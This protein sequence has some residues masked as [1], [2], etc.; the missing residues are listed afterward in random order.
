MDSIILSTKVGPDDRI[1][2]TKEAI[3]NISFAVEKLGVYLASIHQLYDYDAMI[4]SISNTLDDFSTA[5]INA[6]CNKQYVAAYKKWGNFGWS[7]NVNIDKK[8]FLTAPN[9][10]K[11]AD[12][13]M[14][15]YCNS[16]T[17]TKMM[18]KLET[19]GV[20]KKDLEEAY[21]DYINGKYKSSVMLLFS[22][23][24]QQ[25]IKRK[26]FKEDGRLKTGAG[27]IGELKKSEKQY[28]GST[29]LNYLQFTLIIYCLLKLFESSEN[30]EIEPDVINRNFLIHGMSEKEVNEDDCLKVW[31]ALYSFVVV[32]PELEKE[33]ILNSI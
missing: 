11:E 7:F 14:R 28:K 21:F 33:I 5:L 29:H 4:S 3:E 1:V 10:L 13:I 15:E 17:I 22:L 9:S 32:Y 25:L 19:A 27:A 23:L 8:F 31:S 24:D 26:I 12:S 18:K 16:E 20:S 30:F 2:S 6:G